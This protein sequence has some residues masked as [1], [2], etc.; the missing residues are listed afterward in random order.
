MKFVIA[1]ILSLV[2]SAAQATVHIVTV[3]KD[4]MSLFSPNEL[5]ADEGDIIEF[6]FAAD[7]SHFLFYLLI[8]RASPFRDQP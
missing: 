2:V 5:V 1:L 7:V 4:D 3:G 6:Q 8:C